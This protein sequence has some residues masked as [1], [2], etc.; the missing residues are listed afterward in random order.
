MSGDDLCG[1]AEGPVGDTGVV[2]YVHTGVLHAPQ[3]LLLGLAHPTKASTTD[4]CGL[5]LVSVVAY[6]RT[7]LTVVM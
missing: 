7:F 4:R 3:L 5:V 1:Q 2:W 6:K